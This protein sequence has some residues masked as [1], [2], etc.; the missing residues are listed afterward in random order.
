MRLFIFFIS[1]NKQRIAKCENSTRKNNKLKINFVEIFGVV[2]PTDKL[3]MVF[4]IE[5]YFPLRLN[6][7]PI[8]VVDDSS[9]NKKMMIFS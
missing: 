8:Y 1:A 4:V 6:L 3:E 7:Q 5:I 2:A 9:T